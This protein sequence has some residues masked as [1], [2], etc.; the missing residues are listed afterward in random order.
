[1]SRL[2]LCIALALC[3]S[4][5]ATQGASHVDVFSCGWLKWLVPCTLPRI[6]DVCVCVFALLDFSVQVSMVEME[7]STLGRCVVFID[8]SM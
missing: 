3:M 8:Q 5:L 2:L 7:S 6:H 1:M 4:C